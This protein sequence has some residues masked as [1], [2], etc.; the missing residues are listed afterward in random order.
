[1]PRYIQSKENKE[2]AVVLSAVMNMY[3]EY[4]KKIL[5]CSDGNNNLY[6]H[7]KW[8]KDHHK[9]IPSGNTGNVITILR[10]VRN[11]LATAY[12]KKHHLGNSRKFE[13]LDCGCGIGNIMLLAKAVRGYCVTGLEYEEEACEI[14]RTLLYGY[15]GSNGEI[16]HQ[17]ILT[18]EHYADYDVI[19]YYAPLISEKG[20][21]AFADKVRDD[22]KV[23][24][25]VVT[26]GGHSG[27]LYKDKRF[28]AIF[29]GCKT[30]PGHIRRMAH[31]KMRK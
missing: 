16:I 10:Y 30:I 25:V 26:Y 4:F 27:P 29:D 31:Q 28:K 12:R 1:M 3:M 22:M 6:P 15:D 2:H 5:G 18:F 7:K 11:H 20:L 8:T 23:G 14:A 21:S 19:Y 24:A 13:F 17:D 9:F